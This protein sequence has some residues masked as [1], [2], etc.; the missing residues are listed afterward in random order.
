M[1]GASG[2]VGCAVKTYVWGSSDGWLGAW[3]L[4]DC[5]RIR[6]STPWLFPFTLL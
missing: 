2:S 4:Y 5:V 3:A 1:G 6:S